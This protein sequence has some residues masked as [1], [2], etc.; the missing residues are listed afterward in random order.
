MHS[1]AGKAVAFGEALK[2]EFKDY[3]VQVKKNCK[4]FADEFIKLGA[5]IVSGGTD[6][7]LFT[8]NVKDGFGITGKEASSI[9]QKNHITVNKNTVPNDTE[10][11]FVTSG[12]RL[13]TA[14]MT[15]R[16]F[17][18]EDFI[19]LARLMADALKNKKDISNEVLS[20]TS[21]LER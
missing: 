2:P 10:S 14:A 12:I 20:M 11:P 9:L 18:E 19:N 13:G 16:G 15:T 21:K 3:I 5:P 7:H 6:N 1:I 4:V 8:V 17:K